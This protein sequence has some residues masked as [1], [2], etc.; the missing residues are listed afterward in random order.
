MK[1]FTSLVAFLICAT[2][3]T[4]EST[5]TVLAVELPPGGYA[6]QIV[7]QMGRLAAHWPDPSGVTITLV[8]NGAPIYLGTGIGS[9]DIYSQL[10]AAKE[11]A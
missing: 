10:T 11:W 4:Q 9:G 8:N 7:Q 1:R 3:H 5:V 2:G 6:T